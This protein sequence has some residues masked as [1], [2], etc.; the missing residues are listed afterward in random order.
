MSME[1]NVSLKS[2]KLVKFKKNLK[3]SDYWSSHPVRLTLCY[4]CRL[5]QACDRDRERGREGDRACSPVC[6]VTGVE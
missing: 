2:Y 1:E 5:A 4:V 6:S 3:N